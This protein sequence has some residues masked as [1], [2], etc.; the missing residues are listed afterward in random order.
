MDSQNITIIIPTLKRL[1]FLELALNSICELQDKPGHV[2]VVVDAISNK[3][4]AELLKK[5]NSLNSTCL[6]NKG[7]K[8]ANGCRN[9]GIRYALTSHVLF[10]DDDDRLSSDYLNG[11]ELTSKENNTVCLFGEKEF[12]LS[13]SLNQPLN[14][15]VK[16][17]DRITHNDLKLGNKIGTTSGV[18]VPT[19]I[20]K[21]ISFDEDLPAMQDYDYWLRLTAA[22]YNFKLQRKK[23]VKYTIHV[24][25]NQISHQYKSHLE[26]ETII[27]RKYEHW[28]KTNR[29]LLYKSLFGMSQKAIHRRSYLVFIRRL[30]KNSHLVTPKLLLLLAPYRLL[31]ILGFYST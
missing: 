23:I 21:E 25:T 20:S 14:K 6:T 4:E 28:D 27:R 16:L 13:D 15:K 5:Y 10:L 3:A 24:N 26:A 7:R 18:I 29:Q 8:G 1:G 17:T 31:N 30:V 2:I 12:Y 9:T 22:G 11:V 19:A